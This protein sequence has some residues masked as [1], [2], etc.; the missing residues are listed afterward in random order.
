MILVGKLMKIALL[1]LPR[2]NYVYKLYLKYR[3]EMTRRSL[4]I[5]CVFF[6]IKTR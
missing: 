1:L 2:K 3:T 5:R 4:E 6:K